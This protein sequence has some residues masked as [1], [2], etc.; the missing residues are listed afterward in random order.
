MSSPGK[1]HHLGILPRFD[2]I[3]DQDERVREVHVVIAR[4]V[5]DQQLPF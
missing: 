2:Q 4:A 3:V 1:W 5:S